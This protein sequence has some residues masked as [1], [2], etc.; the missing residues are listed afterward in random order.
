MIIE[1]ARFLMLHPET[2]SG[3]IATLDALQAEYTKE[4]QVCVS[5]MLEKRCFSLPKKDKQTFFPPAENLSSQ[6]EKNA[7]D[8][9]I[10]ITS[11]W[12]ASGYTNKIKAIIT[13][14]KKY[15]TIDADTAKALYSIGKH[16]I[17]E[18]R[19]KQ[20][21]TQEHLDQYWC[22]LLSET[23]GIKPPT[24]TDKI[25]IRM[26][27]MTCELQT[28]KRSKTAELWVKISTLN[29]G[30]RT[31]LPLMGSSYVQKPED[32]NKGFLARRTKTG[33]WRFEALS[34]KLETL[35]DE[36]APNARHIGVD[37]GLN[38]VAAT[39]DGRL[40]G[41]DLK[42]KFDR[43]YA[44]IKKIRAN[45]QKQGIVTDS[46]RLSRLESKLSGLTK[47][48]VGTVTNRLKNDYPEGTVFEFE[49]LDLRGC[50]GSKRYCYH[51]MYKSAVRKVLTGKNNPA[52]TSQE[53]PSCGYL[54]RANR[55]SIKFR[56][57]S[58]GRLG[59]ADVAGAINILGRSKDQS[60]DCGTP[61]YCVKAILWKRFGESRS[62]SSVNL[63]FGEPVPSG[64]ILTTK[65]VS[66]SCRKALTGEVRIESN[67]VSTTGLNRFGGRFLNTV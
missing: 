58:C 47:T 48:A 1:R 41:R 27:E 50:Q 40:Y 3:K 65:V 66:L 12:A 18:P 16:S 54:N 23:E 25:G 61:H 20:K 56:C 62:I 7:R 15:G 24:I 63:L 9:A 11:S 57:L 8:H 13:E 32:I 26:S 28:P 39:S 43:Q 36:P 31:Y 46:K 38:V 30:R 60:I 19:E 33:K 52:Y 64:R 2:N 29:A 55:R 14:L 45:R 4:V 67:Q 44:K 59:H 10:S 6:I 35:P 5:L 17:C 34:S 42:P 49:D 22:L 53:C 37:V 51:A 21:I